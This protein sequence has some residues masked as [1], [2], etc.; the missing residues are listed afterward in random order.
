MVGAAKD[1][2]SGPGY[3]RNIVRIITETGLRIYKE[4]MPMKRDQ[5]DL[6]KRGGLDRRFQDSKWR[7]RSTVDAFGYPGFSKSVAPFS[8]EP[9]SLPECQGSERASEE[10]Q[11]GLVLDFEPCEDSVVSHL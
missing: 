9:I 1:R 2:S 3:L 7:G 10:R 4:L 6:E 5:L 11:E 8:A